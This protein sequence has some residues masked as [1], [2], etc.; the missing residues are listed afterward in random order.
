MYPKLL[1]PRPRGERVDGIAVASNPKVEKAVGAAVMPNGARVDG[2][3]VAAK[4][5]NPLPNPSGSGV[6]GK[7][8]SAW[9]PR[10]G[11]MVEVNPNGARVGAIVVVR[12]NG[13]TVG[14]RVASTAI[15]FDL[16]T[17]VG[18]TVVPLNPEW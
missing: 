3:A 15:P 9:Y 13:A 11:A 10:A 8:L 17:T 16:A 4:L 12:P 1:M 2:M 7:K 6:D 14:A 5:S 18:P